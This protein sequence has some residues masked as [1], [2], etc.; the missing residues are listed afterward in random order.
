MLNF[1]DF[2]TEST[3]STGSLMKAKS[4]ISSYL[5]RKLKDKVF[6]SAGLEKFSNS[7]TAGYGLRYYAVKSSKSIRFNWESQSG[8]ANNLTSMHVWYGSSR[9]PDLY[10]EFDRAAS[11]V[12]ILPMAVE[13]I[14][15]APKTGKFTLAPLGKSL[16]EDVELEEIFSLHENFDINDAYDDIL[17]M[18]QEPKFTK[19]KVGKK[20]KS[21]GDAIVISLKKMY[22]KAFG[23][24][25][26]I[27][28]I[29]DKKDIK[30]M[31]DEREKVLDEA[32]GLTGTIQRGASSEEYDVGQAVTD[33][34]TQKERI[35]YETQLE[36]LEALTQMMVA[37]SSNALFVA[38]RGGIGKTHTV[39]KILA[40]MGL[41]DGNGYFKNTGSA[42]AAGIY[43]LF[44]KHQN[45]II[46]FDDSD[47][48]LKDQS[49]RN[50]F[51]AATDT[52]PT[53]KLVWNKM[54]PNV[55]EPDDFEDP[56]ELIDAGKIPR[57]FDFKGKVIFISNLPI[58]KL[59]PD[60]ALRTRAFM[61]DID[62]TDAE[63]YEF[64]EKIAGEFPIPDGMSLSADQRLAVVQMLRSSKSKQSA[65]LR[66]LSRGLS[67]Q[68]GAAVVGAKNIEKLINLYA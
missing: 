31:F 6:A 54:G 35:A 34:E 29:G 3:L 27:M 7:N 48:A 2:L 41:Q 65:N 44:F 14:S 24:G 58:D 30:K 15:K 37:G 13:I 46:F 68:A 1:K 50:I 25:N 66:K 12:Q 11:L 28:F 43:S 42:S 22:P 57:Y 5:S 52:K 40:D 53:R 18:L 55:V 8:N 62:P 20:Y 38:G 60:G 26:K 16:K 67:M 45:D 17:K 39:E 33:L 56:Q 59:D 49:A 63:I 64:M 4:L 47:D 61:I 36:H 51:K 23:A 10:V 32:G 21:A 19:S 9:S